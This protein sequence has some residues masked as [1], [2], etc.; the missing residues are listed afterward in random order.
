MILEEI[1]AD[2][3]RRL[4]EHMARISESQMRRMAEETKTREARLL[5]QSFKETGTFY[6]R[7]I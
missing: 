1:V 5:L 3:K 4:P 6:Y 7:R 2:K